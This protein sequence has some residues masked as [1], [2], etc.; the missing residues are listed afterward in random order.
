MVS[1]NFMEMSPKTHLLISSNDFRGSSILF[2]ALKM[3][4]AIRWHFALIASIVFL[5]TTLCGYWCQAQP[6]PTQPTRFTELKRLSDGKDVTVY[7]E[8]NPS[9]CER[10]YFYTT[11]RNLWLELKIGA[12]VSGL[13]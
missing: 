6:K 9:D 12:T 5:M 10:N 1:K 4:Q 13:D 7:A 3:F 11:Y 8:P 2:R